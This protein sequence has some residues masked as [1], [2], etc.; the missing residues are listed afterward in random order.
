MEQLKRR[1]DEAFPTLSQQEAY[2]KD[3]NRQAAKWEAEEE[4]L[5]GMSPSEKKVAR[6]F[7][8][9]AAKTQGPGPGPHRPIRAGEEELPPDS[10]ERG[11]R[12]ESEEY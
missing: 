5:I 4:E 9:R 8:R 7:A 10:E 2:V 3:L 12:S 1:C 6:G 11:I